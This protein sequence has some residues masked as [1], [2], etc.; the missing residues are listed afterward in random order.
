ML[1]AQGLWV[2]DP[3]QG[4]T[5]L[6]GVDC[7]LQPGKVAVLLG[8]SGAGKTLLA[9]ALCGMLP[10]GLRLGQGAVFFR[11][12]RM[13]ANDWTGVRGR[14]VFYAPQ[15]AAASFNPVLPLGRQ[16]RE[17]AVACGGPDLEP[18]LE[19]LGIADPRRILRSYPHELSGGECQRCLLAMAL[20][21]GAGTLLLDEP[22][23]EIDPD[24]QDDFIRQLRQWQL[25][26]E[27]T[28]LLVSHHL[29]FV[30]RVADALHV[31]ASGRMVAC[32]ADARS[33]AASGH[34]DAM[35]IARALEGK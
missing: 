1:R 2:D 35:E 33:L 19:R 30:R 11:G 28:V 32:G 21:S 10:A 31:L 7:H 25:R 16:V 12:R 3:C 6:H 26:R 14:Q 5:L 23:A 8:A 4:R 15:N 9:R 17:C 13:A 34:A 24:A 27:L 29:G 20:A 22:L 18:L